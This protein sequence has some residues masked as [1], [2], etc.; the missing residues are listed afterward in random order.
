YGVTVGEEAMAWSGVA[1]VGKKSEWPEW[2][3]TPEIQ[4]RVGPYPSPGGGGPAHP[5]GGG[6]LFL[7]PGGKD[8]PHRIHGPNQPDD[9]GQAI[10]SGCIRMTNED[11]IDLYNRVKMGATVIVL[12]PGQ[13]LGSFG[14]GPFGR[15]A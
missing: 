10:S 8:T 6:G 7:F 9:I 14:R 5:L 1:H 15:R 13:G 12:A 2:I 11:V 4:A 3:P